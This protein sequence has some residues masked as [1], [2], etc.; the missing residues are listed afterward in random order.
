M[1]QATVLCIDDDRHQLS[2]LN[3]LL[4]RNHFS[5]VNSSSESMV[6]EFARLAHPDV[7]LLDLSMPSLSGFEVCRRLKQDSE[8]VDI[9]VVILSA[10][11]DQQTQERAIAEGAV[12]FVSKPYDPDALVA[13]L[14]LWVE[15]YRER[16]A[17]HDLVRA[18]REPLR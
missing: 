5:I 14:R 9:P 18:N 13:T 8:L 12:T 15:T 16:N 1:K 4:K 17:C 10:R 6:F 7:I 2:A 11:D 3:R